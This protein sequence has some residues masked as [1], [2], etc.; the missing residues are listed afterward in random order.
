ML[1]THKSAFKMFFLGR[2]YAYGVHLTQNQK[3]SF[4]EHFKN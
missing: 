3:K 1:V 2:N 4:N